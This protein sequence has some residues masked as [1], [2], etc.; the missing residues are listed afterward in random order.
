MMRLEP[1]CD[2]IWKYPLVLV[3]AFSLEMPAGSIPLSVGMTN[4]GPMVWV[5]VPSCNPEVEQH[6]FH[7]RG[8]GHPFPNLIAYRF[9]GT[10]QVFG[11]VYHLF[12]GGPAPKE[13]RQVEVGER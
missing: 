9:I 7:L 10:F 6:R 4:E 12:D 2:T 3:D 1:D 8:T 5:A 11:L 13:L